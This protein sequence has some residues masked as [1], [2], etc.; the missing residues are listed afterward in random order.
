MDDF[1]KYLNTLEVAQVLKV[2]RET[3]RDYI[4]AGKLIAI[5]SGR[6]NLIPK[7]SLDSYLQDLHQRNTIKHPART[8][9]NKGY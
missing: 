2:S 5:K 1:E 7:S 3:I 8:Q 9:I 4:K 6:Q